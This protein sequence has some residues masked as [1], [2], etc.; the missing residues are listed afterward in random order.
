L[1][2]IEKKLDELIADVRAGRRAETVLTLAEDD[3]ESEVQWNLWKKELAEEGFSK[4]EIEGHK[5]WI[6]AALLQRIQTGEQWPATTS[7]LRIAS[8]EEF[9]SPYSGGTSPLSGRR[10]E[11]FMANMLGNH[12]T[13]LKSHMI[14]ITPAYQP[15]LSPRSMR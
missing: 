2:R 12:S 4:V 15:T 9:S 11:I 1:G 7:D 10:S 13:L 3:N 6:K 14:L 5:D 8:Q